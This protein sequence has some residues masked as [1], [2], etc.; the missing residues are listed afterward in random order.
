MPS[1]HFQQVCESSAIA[2]EA[3]FTHRMSKEFLLSSLAGSRACL[4]ESL[5][6]MEL[7]IFFTTL[8]Q[9]FRFTPP[10]G[11]SEDEL[12]LTPGEGVTVCPSPHKLCAVPRM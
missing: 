12:D 7:F 5:A 3:T 4:G 8:L 2:V 1:Y 9:H 11:V 10:P 6:K